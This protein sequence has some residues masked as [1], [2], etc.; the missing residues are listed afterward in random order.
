MERTCLNY[1]GS[2]SILGNV[3]IHEVKVDAQVSP[4]PR[5]VPS[6]GSAGASRRQRP[7]VRFE[8]CQWH[9]GEPPSTR[10]F[11][12]LLIRSKPSRL[13]DKER[14]ADLVLW[15]DNPA[16]WECPCLSFVQVPGMTH[17]I[18]TPA[19]RLSQGSILVSL[20]EEPLSTAVYSAAKIRNQT[21]PEPPRA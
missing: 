13:R 9:L 11:H 17:M 5:P 2:L 8:T 6:R 14:T 12:C 3:K 21:K 7:F 19:A 18:T 16:L 15:N 4:A 10:R 20:G 1:S